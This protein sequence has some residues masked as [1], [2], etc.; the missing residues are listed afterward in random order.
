MRRLFNDRGQTAG[1]YVD[2]TGVVRGFRREADGT[3]TAIERAGAAPSVMPGIALGPLPNG[4]NNRGQVVGAYRDSQFQIDGFLAEAGRFA[5][6]R[7]PGARA[8]SY[9]TDIDDRGRIIG[10]DR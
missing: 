1:Y 7:P 8:E 5:A 3:V 6:L 4:L 9:A 2:A 10:Y